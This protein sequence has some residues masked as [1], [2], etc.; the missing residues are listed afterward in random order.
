MLEENSKIKWNNQAEGNIVPQNYLDWGC[1]SM[2]EP[3]DSMFEAL[4]M[5][6]GIIKKIMS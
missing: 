5:I 4:A 1:S 6:S 2:V 3:R